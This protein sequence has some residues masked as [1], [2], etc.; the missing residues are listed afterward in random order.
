MATTATHRAPALAAASTVDTD[1]DQV[2]RK[3]KDTL[4]GPLSKFDFEGETEEVKLTAMD[5]LLLREAC[6][7]NEA[8]S[9]ALGS[10]RR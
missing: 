8:G 7:E 1:L 4:D 6:D 10:S 3:R 9:T 5:K 2:V